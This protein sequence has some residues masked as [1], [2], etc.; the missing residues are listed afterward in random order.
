[1]DSRIS[2]A[3]LAGGILALIGTGAYFL[4]KGKKP[5]VAKSDEYPYRDEVIDL[6]IEESFPASDSPSFTPISH[7]G[8]L[9]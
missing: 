5:V 2:R 7:I 4:L 9:N 8:G 3:L 6:Y 1:M